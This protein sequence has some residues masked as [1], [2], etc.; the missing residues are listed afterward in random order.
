MPGFLIGLGVGGLIGWLVT[1]TQ[2][3]DIIKKAK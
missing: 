2:E 1:D 3:I